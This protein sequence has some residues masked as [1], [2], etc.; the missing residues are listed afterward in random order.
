MAPFYLS[1]F[2]RK[3]L[4]P[5]DDI[6][7]KKS[8]VTSAA[9]A[10]TATE[11]SKTPEFIL[12]LI[13]VIVGNLD[14]IFTIFTFS[15]FSQYVQ[16]ENYKGKRHLIDL[17][18]KKSL[19]LVDLFGGLLWTGAMYS[20]ASGLFTDFISSRMKRPAMEAKVVIVCFL[21]I[22]D[23]ISGLIM[24]GL[25]YEKSK[26]SAMGVVIIFNTYRA[27]LYSLS[28]VY[29]RCNYPIRVF[30]TLNGINRITMGRFV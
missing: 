7:E 6:A 12:F 4:W 22:L 2:S 11:I 17:S 29:I 24:H 16:G 14:C 9:G 1:P 20:V 10:M 5:R 3:S 8:G 18:V 26:E 28:T 30:G 25:Q 19:A 27:L 23:Q 21:I 15:Q 13:W